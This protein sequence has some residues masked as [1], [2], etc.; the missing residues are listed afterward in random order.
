MSRDCGGP[1]GRNGISH[2]DGHQRR[3]CFGQVY[4]IYCRPQCWSLRPILARYSCYTNSNMSDSL[5]FVTVYG[6]AAVVIPVAFVLHFFLST[7]LGAIAMSISAATAYISYHIL[8]RLMAICLA[9]GTTGLIV[10]VFTMHPHSLGE[11][12]NALSGADYLHPQVNPYTVDTMFSPSANNTYHVFAWQSYL[13]F[14][15]LAI[16]ILSA[17][18]YAGTMLTRFCPIS[19]LTKAK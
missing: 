3:L 11:L 9:V 6:V 16:A 10:I 18:A 4:I 12:I 7:L 13:V 14:E 8:P 17:C 2:R 5:I 1:A 15:V 19:R